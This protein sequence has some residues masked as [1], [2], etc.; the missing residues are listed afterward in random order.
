V[1]KNYAYSL[2]RIGSW[3][4]RVI[5]VSDPSKMKVVQEIRLG[6]N[7]MDEENGLLY[8]ANGLILSTIEK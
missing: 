6:G 4:F 1:Y 7:D 3:G 8:T 2:P 5:D